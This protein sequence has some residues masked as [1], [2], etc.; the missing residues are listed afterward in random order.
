MKHKK[1]Q[2]NLSF[3][4]YK[5]NLNIKFSLICFNLPVI[6]SN[7]DSGNLFDSINGGGSGIK[8]LRRGSTNPTKDNKFYPSL[9]FSEITSRSSSEILPLDTSTKTSSILSSE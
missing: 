9:I 1:I 4:G 3:I 6:I 7:A 2:I 8:K 5:F